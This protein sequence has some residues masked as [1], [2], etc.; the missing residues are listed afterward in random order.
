VPKP[1]SAW[2]LLVGVEYYVI[3]DML[4]VGVEYYV[5]ADRF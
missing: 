2:K 1:K 4:L 3:A 5:I